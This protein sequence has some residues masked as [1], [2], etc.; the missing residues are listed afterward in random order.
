[1]FSPVDR[2]S[3]SEFCRSFLDQ[4]GVNHVALRDLAQEVF[5]KVQPTATVISLSD[6]ISDRQRVLASV[7]LPEGV[8]SVPLEMA[9]CRV[10][11]E[12]DMH[13]YFSNGQEDPI[14][15]RHP[16]V[17][18]GKLMAYMGVPLYDP[19]DEPFGAICCRSSC[20]REWSEDDLSAVQ[21]ASEKISKQIWKICG[22]E[23]NLSFASLHS[24]PRLR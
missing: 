22:H 14:F 23:F 7:G 12:G 3:F 6:W 18:D 19:F 16:A 10:V 8:S 20:V 2:R 4:H 24:E 21:Q 17:M 15:H 9:I 11:A 1:M 5:D 13:I